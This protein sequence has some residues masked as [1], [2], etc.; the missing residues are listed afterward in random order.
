[1]EIRTNDRT[2]FRDE[3]CLAGKVTRFHLAFR[4]KFKRF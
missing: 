1:M 3:D 2:V 4:T